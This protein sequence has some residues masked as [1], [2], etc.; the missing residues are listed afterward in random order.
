MTLTPISSGT[1]GG[2][3]KRL[4]FVFGV[5]RSGTSALTRLLNE[6]PRICIGIERYK[7]AFRKKRVTAAYF[8]ER[9]FFDF[10]ASDTNITPAADPRW[11]EFYETMRRRWPQ[12]EIVGD[13]IPI[14]QSYPHVK[15]TFPQASIVYIC[16][17]LIRVASSWNV[18]AASKSDKWPAHN[19]YAKAVL[20]WNQAN[21]LVRE[22]AGQPA[23][24]L[25]VLDY[26]RLFSGD[27]SE[28]QRMMRFLS[29]SADALTGPYHHYVQRYLRTVR[30]KSLS[31]SDAEI[32]YLREHADAESYAALRSLDPR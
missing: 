4:V 30:D 15:A 6:H 21:R 22:W 20:Q 17:D 14:I 28:L 2:A 16:R 24:R 13:K 5:A 12:A 32:R 19:D 25:L 26:E 10:R 1:C 18:R 27:L 9:R 31:L 29:V 7:Y 23:M 3:E 11:A 8:E